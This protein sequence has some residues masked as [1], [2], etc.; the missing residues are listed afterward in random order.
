MSTAII[1]PDAFRPVFVVTGDVAADAASAGI[2]RHDPAIRDPDTGGNVVP[3]PR[4]GVVARL[5]H[6][7]G[8]RAVGRGPTVMIAIEMGADEDPAD[9]AAD[10]GGDFVTAITGTDRRSHGSQGSD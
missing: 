10:C 2:D 6:D 1:D 8:R 5:N 3:M 9:K 4:R 7:H